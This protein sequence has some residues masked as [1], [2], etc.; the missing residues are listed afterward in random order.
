MAV[1][2]SGGGVLSLVFPLPINF[3]FCSFDAALAG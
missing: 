2:G 1:A 3:S